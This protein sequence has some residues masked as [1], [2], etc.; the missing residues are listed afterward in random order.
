MGANKLLALRV[1]SGVP[2]RFCTLASKMPKPAQV[3]L[4]YTET[5]GKVV[6]RVGSST[7]Y[8]RHFRTVSPDPMLSSYGIDKMASSEFAQ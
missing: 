1:N 8:S 4:N 6:R 5:T 3:V 2:D 7:N